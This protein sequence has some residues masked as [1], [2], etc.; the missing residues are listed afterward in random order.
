M[1]KLLLSSVV[2]ALLAGPALAE[3]VPSP[4]GMVILTVSGEVAA[5]N[6]GP[7]LE[8]GRDLM[9]KLGITFEKAVEFDEA[10]LAALDQGEI[11]RT[12][13]PDVLEGTFTGPTLSAVLDAAGIAEVSLVS[14]MTLDGYASEIPADFITSYEPIL[15]TRL[16][17]EPFG[18]GGFGPLAMVFPESEDPAVTEQTKRMLPW[19]TFYLAVE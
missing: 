17:D 14:V 12:I 7:A 6:R 2:T 3:G 19:A 11:S 4:E 15:A 9:S 18:I 16:D 5:P 13:Y 8:D 1:K 10:A